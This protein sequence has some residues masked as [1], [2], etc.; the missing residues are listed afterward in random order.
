MNVQA[1]VDL[2]PAAVAR[3]KAA[4]AA[5][6]HAA[7]VRRGR[8]VHA[9]NVA[10]DQQCPRLDARQ[11]AATVPD[12][13]RGE[14]TRLDRVIALG[15]RRA[16]IRVGNRP[17]VAEVAAEILALLPTDPDAERHR[18]DLVNAVDGGKGPRGDLTPWRTP[19]EDRWTDME[20]REAHNLRRRRGGR[21]MADLPPEVAEASRAFYRIIRRRVRGQR[22]DGQS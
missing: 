22:Q 2:S 6:V 1:A 15:V 12:R 7:R 13:A 18:V 4:E 3:L 11:V 9:Q 14:V 21:L 20:M 10:R 19:A 5:R 8:L 17:T 16:Q